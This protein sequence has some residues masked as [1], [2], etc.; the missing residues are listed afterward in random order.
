MMEAERDSSVMFA[1]KLEANDHSYGC[2]PPEVW[3]L[4]QEVSVQYTSVHPHTAAVQTQIST[5]LCSIEL[6][7]CQSKIRKIRL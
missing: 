3:Q 6:P 2:Q 7:K 4:Q 1:G 5:G